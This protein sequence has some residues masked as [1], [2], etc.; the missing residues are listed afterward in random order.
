MD[1]KHRNENIC[2]GV[3]CNICR[4]KTVKLFRNMKHYL[5][6]FVNTHDLLCVIVV[7]FVYIVVVESKRSFLFVC[8]R[9]ESTWG[10]TGLAVRDNYLNIYTKQ[11]HIKEF[12]QE[13]ENQY[14]CIDAVSKSAIKL[15]RDEFPVRM[16]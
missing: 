11:D 1:V 6:R 16:T 15:R 14:G 12:M 2:H 5:K 7:N 3:Q 9:H 13:I 8:C 4:E 10:I